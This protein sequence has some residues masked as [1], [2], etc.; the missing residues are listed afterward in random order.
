MSHR[1]R[2]I[3]RFALAA[4]LALPVA[5]Q[6]AQQ[7]TSLSGVVRLNK[8]PA[9]KEILQ[10]KFPRPAETTLK[11]GLRLLVLEDH[12][13]PTFTL[14]L[15]FWASSLK[16]PPDLPGLAGVTASVLRLGTKTLDSRQIA[17]RLAELG[18]RCLRARA[19]HPGAPASA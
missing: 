3:P 13:A 16:E 18:D 11:N 9:S 15:V 14:S 4:A 5:A 17:E 8:A 19:S 10:V 6:Q 7:P 2:V 12:R 1:N